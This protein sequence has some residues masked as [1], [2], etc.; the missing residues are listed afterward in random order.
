MIENEKDVLFKELANMCKVTTEDEWDHTNYYE[1]KFNG[2]YYAVFKNRLN[3]INDCIDTEK[4][5]GVK[6]T[7]YEALEAMN[8][9]VK[10]NVPFKS[11]DFNDYGR[12]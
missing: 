8:Q 1:V 4:V 7:Y 5:S 3:K 12:I 6:D 9:I 2:F 11:I 10:E